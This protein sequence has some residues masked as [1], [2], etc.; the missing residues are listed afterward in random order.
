MKTLPHLAIIASIATLCIAGCSGGETHTARA[1]GD[2]LPM[3]TAHGISNLISDSG[4][5]RYKMIAEEWL[6]YE[7]KA[8]RSSR[9]DFLKGFFMQ[10]Y[11]PDWHIEWY[12]RSDT[13]YCHHDDLWELR[14]RVLLR[15]NAGTTF[16]TEEL[17]W[18]MAHH[19][20]YSTQ[21]VHIKEPE[22]ELQG[23][24]FRSN[25]MMTKYAIYNSSGM[26]PVSDMESEADSLDHSATNVELADSLHDITT[27]V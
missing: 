7:A 1:V 11:A 22:R 20:V 19:E 21:F 2:S 6:I 4:V 27:Q 16:R 25:E 26:L 8:E 13:A 24:N 23:Y 14:G 9:W 15:N 3:M 12:I 17:F 10:K 18:D 5:V